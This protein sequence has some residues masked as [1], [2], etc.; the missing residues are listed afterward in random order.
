[1]KMLSVFLLP[2]AASLSLA[3]NSTTPTTPTTSRNSTES[4]TE[5]ESKTS[6]VLPFYPP[7]PISS[8][9]PSPTTSANVVAAAT[10]ATDAYWQHEYRD[11]YAS[12]ITVIST[13]TLVYAIDCAPNSRHASYTRAN[14]FNSAFICANSVVGRGPVTVT[15]G[16]EQWNFTVTQ[17]TR[18]SRRSSKRMRTQTQFATVEVACAQ[19]SEKTKRC[20]YKD[21]GDH[22]GTV[23]GFQDYF[24]T[25]NQALVTVTA[26]VDKLP[27][28]VLSSLVE[29]TTVVVST[30]ASSSQSRSSSV[31]TSSSTAAA[32]KITGAVGVD[33]IFGAAG[34]LGAAVFGV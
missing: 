30:S 3:Q 22:V 25:M 8:I 11:Y 31:A 21:E 17:T 20:S 34:L 5:L 4:S 7:Y 10:P 16:P 33:V 18:T 6:I 2:L 27:K 32:P 29:A 14:E 28:D 23:K 19:L 12:I 1:M 24:S 9:K 13:S 15:Q 26:G